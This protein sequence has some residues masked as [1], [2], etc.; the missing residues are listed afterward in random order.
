MATSR[1]RPIIVADGGNVAHLPESTLQCVV[2]AY[3]AG[4]DAIWLRV[5]LSADG[6]PVVY[7]HADLSATTN[8][9]GTVGERSASELR[10][11]GCAVGF[12]AAEGKPW[13][14]TA[15]RR[16]GN[17]PK[18]RIATLEEV[19]RRLANEVGWYI[20]P[21]GAIEPVLEVVAAI[22]ARMGIDTITWVIPSV[23]AA[24]TVRAHVPAAALALRSAG[25]TGA[26]ACLLA[27]I[28]TLIVPGGPEAWALT[29]TAP[30]GVAVI[31]RCEAEEIAAEHRARGICA[32]SV[33]RLAHAIRGTRELLR[34]DFDGASIDRELWVAGISSGH[35]VL[36]SILAQRLAEHSLGPG[37]RPIVAQVF[38]DR[39]RSEAR[40]GQ[41][42]GKLHVDIEQGHRYASAGVVSTLTIPDPFQVC[43]DFGFS[44]PQVANMMVLAVVNNTAF[45]RFHHEGRVDNPR[46][47]DEHPV[48]DSHGTPPFVSMEREEVEGFRIMHNDG[49]AGVY[50]WFGNLYEP[51]VGNGASRGGKLM[52]ERRGHLFS[53]YYQD[54]LNHDWVGVGFIENP[55]MHSRV[56]VRLVSKHYP[57]A[58]AR[59][60]VWSNQVTYDGFRANTWR[61]P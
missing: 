35:E 42:D 54:E 36:G 22:A 15:N 31:V 37:L 13:D 50:E 43:V 5:Q 52:L 46:F 14:G 41:R 18:A 48:F 4:A 49:S 26:E 59:D 53:G 38:D 3:T 28:G 27:G 12:R 21:I 9:R 61:M 33:T 30:D 58:G 57:K 1:S 20:E 47:W 55:S 6:V 8:G 29:A 23:D 51:D 24:A 44:N 17:I 25:A 40:V 56:Y 7:A 34:D 10:A 32:R 45:D 16:G 11:L 60:P 39:T 2:S 19:W